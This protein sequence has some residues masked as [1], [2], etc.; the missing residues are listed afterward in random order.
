M[1]L[2]TV[3]EKGKRL[4]FSFADVLKYHGP[5]FPGGVAHGFKALEAG[6]ARLN[7]G[8]P[9]ERREL[10]V[11]T[12]FPG[13]GARDA[14]ELV[15][16]AVTE[17]R[18]HLD[19]SLGDQSVIAAAKGRYYFKLSYRDQSVELRLRSGIVVTEFIELGCIANKS[20]EQTQR[21]NVLKQ[22]MADRIMNLPACDVYGASSL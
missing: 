12:A 15:T 2:L 22:E 13:P 7:A 11:S 9:I 17:G 8:K 3:V 10:S 4:D 1:T 18:Y 16:R 6:L 14:F 5:E 20:P 19:T 21:S